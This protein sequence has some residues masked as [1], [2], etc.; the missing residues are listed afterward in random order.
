MLQAMSVISYI[1]CH[2]APVMFYSNGKEVASGN[3]IKKKR[4]Q[5][6][7]SSVVCSKNSSAS[8]TRSR[9]VDNDNSGVVVNS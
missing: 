5:R 9:A 1:Y 3:E 7:S 2:I 6:R 4:R 8:R